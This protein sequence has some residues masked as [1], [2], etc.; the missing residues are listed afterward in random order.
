MPNQEHWRWLINKLCKS[1]LML[2]RLCVSNSKVSLT[3][4]K[5]T[6]CLCWQNKR[7]LLPCGCIWWSATSETMLCFFYEWV[8]LM[9]SRIWINEFGQ[10]F[11][12]RQDTCTGNTL[13]LPMCLWKNSECKEDFC[14]ILI[15]KT[16]FIPVLG[17]FQLHLTFQTGSWLMS[18]F[19]CSITFFKI[20]NDFW[21][22][23]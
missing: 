6:P 5:N 9:I 13:V 10:S 22:F 21:F 11:R 15:T 17:C 20:I 1:N 3:R 18:L 14:W 23:P 19:P 4:G 2:H 8:N 16:C 12:Q 7:K